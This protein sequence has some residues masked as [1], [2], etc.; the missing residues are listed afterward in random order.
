MVCN[1]ARSFVIFDQSSS[2]VGAE[3]KL[4]VLEIVKFQISKQHYCQIDYHTNASWSLQSSA[5]NLTWGQQLFQQKYNVCFP[6][7]DLRIF[8]QLIVPKY[9]TS[10]SKKGNKRRKFGLGQNGFN[11][12]YHLIELL[13]FYRLFIRMQFRHDEIMIYSQLLLRNIVPCQRVIYQAPRLY[14]FFPCSTQ[15]TEIYPAHKC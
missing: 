3:T 9:K 6:Q 15:L 13:V 1:L 7:V 8:Y 12:I 4:K 2:E 10:G 14:N 11:L 5:T